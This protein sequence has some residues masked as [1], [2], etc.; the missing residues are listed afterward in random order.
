MRSRKERVRLRAAL[1]IH[2]QLASA[3]QP[4]PPALALPADLWGEL[5]SAAQRAATA[6]RREYN[7]ALSVVR[8]DYRGHANRL[9]ARLQETLRSLD[10]VAQPCPFQ[11][12]REIWADLLALESEFA[13]VDID[14]QKKTLSLT[15]DPIVLEGIE[16]GR[17]QVVLHWQELPRSRAYDVVALDPHSAAS[18]ETTTHPHVR[19]ETL[20]EGDG[21]I[22]IRRALE[23][24]RLFDFAL[25]VRSLL[26]TYNAGSA[27]VPLS[28]WNGSTCC[29]CGCLAPEDES[30]SCDRCDSELCC[31]CRVSCSDCERS[32]CVDCRERCHDCEESYCSVCLGDCS[33]CGD[34]CCR[35][36]LT[37]GR[38]Q[39]CC[40][41]DG[42]TLANETPLTTT[43]HSLEDNA[44]DADHNSTTKGPP[45][46]GDEAPDH[47]PF[48]PHGLG[49]TAVPA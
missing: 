18:D 26:A 31:D 34:T 16:L 15:T 17:F 9:I 4:P 28:Q 24:G 6:T 40:E 3:S 12:P 2:E 11:A 29:D 46:E 27:Y 8:E 5:V 43:T 30:T 41:A 19:D 7:R 39:A 22:P 45:R 44:R 48:H 33:N 14:L 20:C 13:E 49:Q 42:E 25:L 21:R 38:C 37:A 1:Q 47:T 36:C 23:Q 32:C 35:S 10:V